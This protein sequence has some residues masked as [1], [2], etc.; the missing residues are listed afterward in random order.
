MSEGSGSE[1]DCSQIVSPV[2]EGDDGPVSQRVGE[3]SQPKISSAQMQETLHSWYKIDKGFVFDFPEHFMEVPATESSSMYWEEPMSSKEVIERLRGEKANE[4]EGDH[5]IQPIMA[6]YKDI[7]SSTQKLFAEHKKKFNS[8]L[9]HWNVL[10]S[11]KA[12]N[13]VPKF[14]QMDTPVLKTELFPDGDISNL[15]TEFRS[16]LDKAAESMVKATIQERE[17]IDAKLRRE[18][19]ELVDVV[20][21]SAMKKW[22]DAQRSIECTFNRW[23][24]IFPVEMW[25]STTNAR[26]AIPISSVIFRTAM[27][28][29]QSNICRERETELQQKTDAQNALQRETDKRRQAQSKASSLPPKEAEKS[30]D[31]RMEEKLAP[32]REDLREIKAML[33]SNVQALDR[34]DPSRV[35]DRSAR[36][37]HAQKQ[38]AAAKA[39]GSSAASR[40]RSHKG[41]RERPQQGP[42]AS[43]NADN[44]ATGRRSSAAD[45]I[46]ASVNGS[47]DGLR[48]ERRRRKRKRKDT[49][50]ASN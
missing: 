47:E 38:A 15:K 31:K 36:G 21:E 25:N 46:N 16:I 48:S 27:K 34:A 28:E 4:P 6:Y 17:K 49:S 30:L 5:L 7:V 9:H 40:K 11:A 3:S 24:L 50:Q 10:L 22:M 2:N 19:V 20:R 32:M 43:A 18:A 26:Q 13:K 42:S 23:D 8:N 29:C 37:A 33:L 45:P 44:P 1:R 35:D 14:L 39:G 41:Q 12:S